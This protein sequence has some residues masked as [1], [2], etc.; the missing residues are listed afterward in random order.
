M[1]RQLLQRSWGHLRYPSACEVVEVRRAKAGAEAR[2]P[3][4]AS[5]WVVATSKPGSALQDRCCLRDRYAGHGEGRHGSPTAGSPVRPL[6]TDG[7]RPSIGTNGP[8]RRSALADA[9]RAILRLST[10]ESPGYVLTAAI[11]LPAQP[12]AGRAGKGG[13]LV[14]VAVVLPR[15]LRPAA[16]I[17]RGNRQDDRRRQN[18]CEHCDPS[19]DLPHI[20]SFRPLRFPLRP[21]V[22]AMAMMTR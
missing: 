5:L 20:V 13:R 21:L 2:H 1:R 9:V 7:R 4:S 3:R 10:S 11:P 16:C 19:N 14:H 22:E 8:R 6:R 17:R 12:L 15:D 18:R